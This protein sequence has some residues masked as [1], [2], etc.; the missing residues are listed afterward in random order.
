MTYRSDLE[1]A[2]AMIRAVGFLR[3]DGAAVQPEGDVGVRDDHADG[4]LDESRGTLGLYARREHLRISGKSWA[5]RSA[6]CAHRHRVFAARE[7]GGLDGT[8]R[9]VGR[10]RGAG[11]QRRREAEER[12]DEQQKTG[13]GEEGLR[14]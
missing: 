5:L 13:E 1:T 12:R 3:R 6:R 9:Q 8:G 2:H 11:G 14:A 10:R 4:V 7:R